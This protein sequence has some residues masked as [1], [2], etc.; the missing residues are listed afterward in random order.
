M[1]QLVS[2]TLIN[3]IKIALMCYFVN[4]DWFNS[5]IICSHFTYGVEHTHSILN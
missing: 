3:H 5:F 1:K 4:I 2:K